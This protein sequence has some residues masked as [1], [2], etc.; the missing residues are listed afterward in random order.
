[1]SCACTTEY[2]WGCGDPSCPAL[3]NDDE[4]PRAE[5]CECDDEEG[6]SPCPVHG[7]NEEDDLDLNSWGAS[8]R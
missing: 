7:M 8:E 4:V 3:V 1:M 2:L 5:G 6:D